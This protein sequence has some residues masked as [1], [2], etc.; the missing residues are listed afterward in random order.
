MKGCFELFSSKLLIK[1][2][3]K[4]NLAFD[5]TPEQRPAIVCK[6]QGQQQMTQL[7]GVFEILSLAVLVNEMFFYFLW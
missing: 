5:S 2:K 6:L 4:L 3:L 1:S 7:Q